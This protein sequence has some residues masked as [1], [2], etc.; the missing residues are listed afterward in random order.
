[1]VD[2][3]IMKIFKVGLRWHVVKAQRGACAD[4]RV[5]NALN[6]LVS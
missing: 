5:S 2:V 4:G 1:M 6:V 3:E